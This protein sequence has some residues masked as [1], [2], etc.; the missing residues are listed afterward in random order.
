MLFLFYLLN[1]LLLIGNSAL[2][3][4]STIVYDNLH[5]VLNLKYTN[6]LL[7]IFIS[8]LGILSAVL[9]IHTAKKCN[10]LYVIGSVIFMNM[11]LLILLR[12]DDF[13]KFINKWVEIKYKILSNI[14]QKFVREKLGCCEGGK[15]EVE[16]FNLIEKLFCKFNKLFRIVM[17]TMFG[18]CS[19]SLILYLNKFR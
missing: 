18:I 4:V 3:I 8:A 6:L 19:L 1:A 15:C 5:A 2:L 14:N 11:V 16:C 9:G 10:K 13:M 12:V 7:L 17:V